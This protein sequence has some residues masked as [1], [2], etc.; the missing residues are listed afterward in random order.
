MN[1]KYTAALF[2]DKLAAKYAKK[3]VPDEAVYQRKIQL[4]QHYLSAS[5][6]VLEFGC[7]TGSTAILHAPKVERIDAT[8]ISPRMITIAKERAQAA[9]ISN[10]SFK[11]GELE[12]FKFKPDSYD[13][14]LGLNIMHLIHSPADTLNEVYRVLKADGI[15]IS[16][17]PLLKN[18]S[19]FVRWIIK[20]MQALGRAPHINF[21]TKDD[22]LKRVTDAGFELV[23]AWMPDKASVFLIAR[24]AVIKI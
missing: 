2:W 13:A 18:E 12:D 24:K 9:N 5:D 1:K 10:V 19:I 23:Q 3:P 21:L 11:V 16:S 15:F 14:V 17:T 4:T 20:M 22:Y 8:D 6:V 7:G